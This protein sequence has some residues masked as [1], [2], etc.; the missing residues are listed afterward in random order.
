MWGK[1]IVCVASSQKGPF[2]ESWPAMFSAFG[3]LLLVPSHVSLPMKHRPCWLCCWGHVHVILVCP[4]SRGRQH[5]Y[6]ITK[7]P[8]CSSCPQM[9]SKTCCF[10]I[11]RYYSLSTV[12]TTD[13][14]SSLCWLRGRWTPTPHRLPIQAGSS[15]ECGFASGVS[16]IWSQWWNG[17]AA[18]G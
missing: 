9:P 8:H 5:W 2:P 16:E 3:F 10:F 18:Q 15:C 12:G 13:L 11:T 17:I 14:F 4:F 6:V 1:A 7:K